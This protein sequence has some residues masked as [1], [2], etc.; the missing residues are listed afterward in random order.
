MTTKRLIDFIRFEARLAGSSTA[1]AFIY[2][3]IL[4]VLKDLTSI[5]L[6]QEQLIVGAISPIT[7]P[8]DSFVNLSGDFQH[9]RS[10]SVRYIPAGDY[11][12]GYHLLESE[13]FDSWNNGPARK[14]QLQAKT[15]SFFPYA[16]SVV[17]DLIVF[18][19]YTFVTTIGDVIEFPI[20]SLEPA[21]KKAVIA[22][23]LRTF[24]KDSSASDADSERSLIRSK[25]DGTTNE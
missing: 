17:G 19:Q 24:G 14:Y 21:V 11:N 5:D 7:A 3:L 20:P 25:G 22:R 15:I 4:E 9:L 13:F 6:Y 1:T 2:E 18:D 10:N 8:G 23:L 16:E 12:R